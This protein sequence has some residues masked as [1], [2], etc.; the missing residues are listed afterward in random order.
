LF[1]VILGLMAFSTS[2]LTSCAI[3]L[4]DRT[5]RDYPLR[6]L[7]R[8]IL[9]APLDLFLYRPVLMWAR[10]RGTWDYLR[11]RKDWDKFERNLRAPLPAPPGPQL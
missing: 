6:A 8:L 5:G 1:A 3:L 7:V 11:G 2:T 9:I 4:H 10:A